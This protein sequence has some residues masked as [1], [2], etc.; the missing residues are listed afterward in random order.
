[1][2]FSIVEAN[3]TGFMHSPFNSSIIKILNDLS[4]EKVELFCSEEHLSALNFDKDEVLFSPIKVLNPGVKR[5]KKFFIEY[6]QSK[7]IIKKS[8]TDF[9]VF[10]SCFPNV[11]FFL[12]KWLKK[13][14]NKKVIFFTHGEAEGLE[15]S[16]KWKVWSYPFWISA[17]SKIKQPENLYRIVLGSSIK[18]HID[19]YFKINVFSIEHPIGDCIGLVNN[20][21][22]NSGFVFGFVGKCT[23]NKGGDVFIKTAQKCDDFD[24]IFRIVGENT[25]KYD[26]IPENLDVMSNGKMMTHEAYENGIK[27]LDYCCFPFPSDTYK[28]TASGALLDAIRFAK[29]VIYI[30]NDYFDSVFEF[31]GDIGFRCETEEDFINTIK[32]LAEN[33]ENGR[34]KKQSENMKSLQKMFL[35]E[36]VKNQLEC[37]FNQI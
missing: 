9:I 35:P 19:K 34:Y 36:N 8:K 15:L 4:N 24:S 12:T 6:K 33:Q 10:L 37:I 30:K 28:F 31:A 5:I 1:M 23:L 32:S 29:P 16:G 18:K 7:E 3:M 26:S 13:Y 27:S 25:I 14:K 2:T 20:H 11:Q 17:C 21:E 22:L